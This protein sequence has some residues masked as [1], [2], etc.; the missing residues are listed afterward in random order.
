M[1]GITIIADKTS[2]SASPKKLSRKKEAE[3]NAKEMM[4]SVVDLFYEKESA[5]KEK[6][7]AREKVVTEDDT[8]SLPHLMSLYE[9]YMRNFNFHK[10]N[11]TMTEEREKDTIAKIDGLFATIEE[12]TSGKKRAHDETSNNNSTVS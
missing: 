7:I 4:K 6:E 1:S 12:R 8:P 9:I 5:M 3:D 2:R 10:E 11:G